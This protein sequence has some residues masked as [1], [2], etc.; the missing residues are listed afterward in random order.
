MM[1]QPQTDQDYEQQVASW[2]Q[3]KQYAQEKATEA[4]QLRDN[5][6]QTLTQ[7]GPMVFEPMLVGSV[8]STSGQAF[9]AKFGLNK[10]ITGLK[11]LAANVKTAA[12]NKAGDLATKA[13]TA[14]IGPDDGKPGIM[15]K[16]GVSSDDLVAAV[17]GGP[18]AIRDLGARVVNDNIAAAKNQ[19]N[20]LYNRLT[21]FG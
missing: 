16:L 18:S 9:L 11:D 20:D 21:R 12:L 17:K 19:A 14:I 5:I 3:M 2:D 4:T 6:G 15:A 1:N 8:N 7:L 13:K 10:K